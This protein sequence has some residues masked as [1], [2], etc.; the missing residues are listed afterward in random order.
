MQIPIGELDFT[1]LPAGSGETR[2][3]GSSEDRAHADTILREIDPARIALIKELI[4]MFPDKNG[5]VYLSRKR[6]KNGELHRS[7]QLSDCF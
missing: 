7:V 6:D 2:A 1:V 3:S 4:G 5:R